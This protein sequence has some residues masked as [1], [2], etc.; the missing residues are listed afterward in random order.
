MK[1]TIEIPDSILDRLRRRALRER[2]T[3]RALVQA[4]LRQFLGEG[5]GG[6][7]QFRLKDG[8]VPGQGPAPG[9]REGDWGRAADLSYEG[10]GGTGGLAG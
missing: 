3:L 1:T 10:R 6:G 2:T 4:A 9:V 5:R 8:S 7:G